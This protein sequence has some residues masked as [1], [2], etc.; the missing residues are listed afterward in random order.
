[1][2][3]LR[4]ACQ[5]VVGLAINVFIFNK[6]NLIRKMYAKYKNIII[7][8]SSPLAYIPTLFLNY[9]SIF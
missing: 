4:L 1:M 2:Q 6:I 8:M 3:L 9:T 5:Y 7:Y